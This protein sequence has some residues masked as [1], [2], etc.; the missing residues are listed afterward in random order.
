MRGLNAAVKERDE[1]RLKGAERRAVADR[2]RVQRQ[3]DEEQRVPLRP[4]S[5]TSGLCSRMRWF[6]IIIIIIIIIIAEMTVFNVAGYFIEERHRWPVITGKTIFKIITEFW[7]K[8][9][10]R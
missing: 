7:K 4:E 10:F 1:D 5:H 3:V 6:I 9:T 8:G 2:L